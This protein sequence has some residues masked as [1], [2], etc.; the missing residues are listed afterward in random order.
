M[1]LNGTLITNETR[2]KRSD[3]F[4]PRTGAV[5]PR[6]ARR[7]FV[8]VRSVGPS[9]EHASGPEPAKHAVAIPRAKQVLTSD[10]IE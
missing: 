5:E 4:V 3:A 9:Y 2:L 7:R 6:N 8:R 1:G 10:L